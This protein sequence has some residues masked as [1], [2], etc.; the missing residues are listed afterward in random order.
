VPRWQEAYDSSSG[1]YYYYCE[2]MQVGGG[3][4]W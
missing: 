1:C 2:E 4:N 3:T